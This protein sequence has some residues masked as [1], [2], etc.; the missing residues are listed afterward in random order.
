MLAGT[1]ATAQSRSG[2]ILGT[3]TDS[4]GA[5]IPG[6]SVTVRNQGTNIERG[7]RTDSAG[8]YEALLLPVGTYT[9]SVSAQG[10]D[11]VET[12]DVVLETEE[13]REI[14]VSLK[15]GAVSESVTVEGAA[16]QV[17]RSDPTLGQVIHAQQV[18]E[19]P[20]NGRDFVQLG[21]LAPGVAK[22]EAAFFNN[23]GISEVTIRGSVSLAVQ[24]MRENAN[25]W[26]LDGV[27]NNELTAGAVAILPSIDGVQEFKVLA[28]N[29]SAEYGSRG[30][31]TVLVTTKSGTNGY[32]GSAYEFLRNDL[33]DARNYFDGPK[34]GKYNQNQFGA[35]IGG[36]IRKDKTFFFGDYEGE[37]VRQGLTILSTV[38]T[39]LMRQG[40][41]T[42]SFPGAPAKAIFDPT[43]NHIDPATG[44]LTRTQFTNNTIPQGQIDKIGQAL[45]NLYPLPNVPGTLSGNYLSNPIKTFGDNK[46][47][48]RID[49]NFSAKDT[50][51]GRVSYDTAAQFYPSGLPGYGA[52]GQTPGTSSNTTFSTEARNVAI[53]ETHTFT[54]ETV[55]Q[56]TVGYN[57]D[58]NRFTVFGDGTNESQTLGIPGANFGDFI[59]SGLS[60]VSLSGGFNSLGSR[61][62]S[63]FQGGTNVYQFG[64]SLMHLRGGH[65]LK[66]GVNV[67]FQ[68]MN[69]LGNT[70]EP[71]SFSFD[72]NW[73][74]QLTTTGGFNSATGSSVASLLLGLPASGV[75]SNQF[76]G[77]VVGRRWKEYRG[78]VEDDW[79][80][81]SS[82]TLNMG[83]A[84]DVT[85]PMKE[86]HNRQAN[87]DPATGQL[88]IPGVNSDANAGVA[89]D[90]SDIQPRFGFAW[91]PRSSVKTVIR[92]GY[93]IFYDVSGVG[94]VQGLYQN[95]P[96]AA[97]LSYTADDIN[98][99]HTLA[100]GFP[101]LTTGPT[102]ATYTG[103][104]VIQQRDFKQGRV[105]QWN[106]NIERQLPGN[107]VF[108][109]AYAG[110]RGV[111]LQDKGINTN[112]A[113]PGPG[114]NPAARRPFPQ[115]N[116]FNY[117]TSRGMLR[118][119]GLQLHAEKK[120]SHGVY[121]LANYTYSKAFTNGLSQNLGSAKGVLYYPL[122]V[123][124]KEDKALSDTDLT[125][126][127]TFSSIYELPF[128]KGRALLSNSNNF[129][130]AIVSGWETSLIERLRT[131][132]PL[133]FS[134]ASNQSGTAVGNRPIMT[135][136]PAMSTSGA[137]T[138]S[139]F[140]NTACLAAPPVGVLSQTPRSIGF[141]PGLANTDFSVVRNIPLSWEN[142]SL[143]FRA[144]FFNLFNTPQ[145]DQPN[146]TFGNANFG[147]IISTVNNPRQIQFALKLVF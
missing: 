82:L 131:G 110:T 101:V 78:F 51:F 38:P 145:F 30:S 77:W 46:F 92:G 128:G 64:D 118:Y 31:A 9:V 66:F 23:R 1:I 29:Y 47:D 84:Y 112:T 65:S 16:V 79:K 126:N 63:P 100:T 24:G 127:F 21:T 87:F 146:T 123:Y 6:A 130:S 15:P 55:N 70:S 99:Q 86:A 2:T 42:E 80:A 140:F 58:F 134:V 33:L 103:N 43:S 44:K 104:L 36:P 83:L 141:G 124:P 90:W 4:S 12:K 37:R 67:R 115:F 139:E 50:V 76:Q 107:I 40:I 88:L 25:D 14:N 81:R 108:T 48:T 91:S 39:A 102:L 135:C 89:T 49:Q 74:A 34:K 35:S 32:H 69:T 61:T 20:L 26:L 8:R 10:M 96:F 132:F 125:H 142:T 116:N 22:G 28:F 3:V 105:M 7:L 19:L 138:V 147:K 72:N 144:E 62:F 129:V 27:D 11:K 94:G 120:T 113:T 111:D 121:F 109:V 5:V 143:Q 41:F 13:T 133:F 117:I 106:L 68:Q 71:G 53:S 73:T 54:P 114:V 60:N 97:D 137:L 95:P 17:E 45:V 18:S 57:R 93:G 119:D 98:I 85:T 56:V 136:N 122:A 52:G 59:T 75:H